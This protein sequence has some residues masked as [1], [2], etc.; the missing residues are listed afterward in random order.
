MISKHASE[1]SWYVAVIRTG[2]EQCVS[3][4]AYVRPTQP[5]P[6][7]TKL[8]VFAMQAE[9]AYQIALSIYYVEKGTSSCLRGG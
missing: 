5:A 8:R 7:K 2:V 6:Q 1:R 9:I 3:I 4:G